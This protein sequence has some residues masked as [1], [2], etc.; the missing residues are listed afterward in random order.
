MDSIIWDGLSTGF[1]YTTYTVVWGVD[2]L[3]L[4]L[5]GYCIYASKVGVSVFMN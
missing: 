2:D 4:I 1:T 3:Q 5:I